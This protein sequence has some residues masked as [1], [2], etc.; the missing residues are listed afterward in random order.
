MSKYTPNIDSKPSG[1]VRAAVDSY[2]VRRQRCLRAHGRRAAPRCDA[3]LRRAFGAPRTLPPQPGA[4][5]APETSP[6]AG[7]EQLAR[8]AVRG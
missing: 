6:L 2:E 7:I 1:E 4:P 3:Q 8:A 5:L